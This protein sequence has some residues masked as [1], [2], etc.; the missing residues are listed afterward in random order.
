MRQFLMPLVA[1]I[2]TGCPPG[3]QS[4]PSF[5]E[6]VQPWF[7]GSCTISGCHGGPEASTGLD[8]DAGESYEMLV[9][10][11]SAQADL[12]RVDP[13]DAENSYLLHKVAGSHAD[14]GGSGD[15]MPPVVGTTAEDVQMLI[16]WIVGGAL[17]D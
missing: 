10:V 4:V 9:G 7:D 2:M 17:N 8:L 12:P 3:E 5:S 16:D 1:L 6:D 11:G 14:V 13:G 15:Q